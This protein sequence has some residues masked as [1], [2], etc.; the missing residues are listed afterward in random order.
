VRV[1]AVSVQTD[2]SLVGLAVVD[3]HEHE[4]DVGLIPD[5]VVRQAAAQNRGEHATI[6]RDLRDERIERSSEGLVNG[7]GLHGARSPGVGYRR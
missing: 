3:R 1:Q 6:A 5:G 2:A 4:I 7:V